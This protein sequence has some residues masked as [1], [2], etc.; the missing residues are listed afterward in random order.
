VGKS[1]EHAPRWTEFVWKQN[2]DIFYAQSVLKS[3]PHEL[4]SLQR[5]TIS[6]PAG[7]TPITSNER[8]FPLCPGLQTLSLINFWDDNDVEGPTLFQQSACASVTDLILG[9]DWEWMDVDLRYMAHFQNTHSL[10]LFSFSAGISDQCTIPFPV[11]VSLPH[12]RLLRL[13]GWV[14]TEILSSI[15]PPENLTVIVEDSDG[16]GRFL[17][18]TATLS[19][20]KIA[21]EMTTLRLNWSYRAINLV[22][23]DTVFE[24]LKSAPSLEALHLSS[25]VGARLGF[26]LKQFRVDHGYSF[27]VCTDRV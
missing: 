14:P 3:L 2:D 15:K 23:L 10:T 19:G 1:H 22:F 27:S 25:R 18:S 8:Q 21:A 5:L 20:T 26:Y 4:P 7:Y 16:A 6:M 12:L 17:D 13:R 24:L 9:N 11:C